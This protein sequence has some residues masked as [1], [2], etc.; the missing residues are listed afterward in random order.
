M[1]NVVIVE[2]DP[3]VAMIN[4]QYIERFP[5]FE[6][7]ASVDSIDKLWEE[8]KEEIPDL[9]LLDV[10]LPGETGIDF[11][12]EVRKEEVSIPIIMITAAN[13]M[14]TIKK[15]L[16]YGVIDFLIKPFTFERFEQAIEKFK[17]YHG[18]TTSSE[19]TDQ[20][21]LDKLLMSENS[22]EG[23]QKKGKAVEPGLPKGLSK[24]TLRKVLREIAKHDD[25]FS[26]E[27]IASE[28]GLSRISTRK[29]LQHLN[30]IGYLKDE[31]KYLTIGRPITMYKVHGNQ[32]HL[33]ADFQ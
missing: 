26:T 11:L 2:D 30:E 15:A 25:F 3:M 24:L 9:I 18:F 20:E 7:I 6:I 21:T 1:V 4:Q 33:I 5:E 23:A 8:L 13:D 28:V 22:N 32:E 12:L 27:D 14:P 17:A 10:Y 16:E 31:L 19:T 29:Y